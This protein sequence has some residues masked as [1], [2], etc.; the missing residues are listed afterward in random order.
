ME[1]LGYQVFLT[2][3]NDK[4]VAYLDTKVAESG[5]EASCFI[6]SCEDG[7]VKIEKYN[8]SLGAKLLLD[9]FY[10]TLIADRSMTVHAQQLLILKKSEHLEKDLGIERLIKLHTAYRTAG[11]LRFLN[12]IC[13]NEE[14]WKENDVEVYVKDVKNLYYEENE[15]SYLK[16][17]LMKNEDSKVIVVWPT[18]P[19]N[20]SFDCLFL[21]SVK[22]I[23][24]AFFCQITVRDNIDAKITECI[25]TE[26]FKKY[27]NV[28][29]EMK[30][31]DIDVR[32]NFIHGKK[33]SDNVEMITKTREN[34]YNENMEIDCY[35]LCLLGQKEWFD[36]E[37]MRKIDGIR[38]KVKLLINVQN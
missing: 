20:S 13:P 2:T 22:K 26:K 3:H 11:C 25:A 18:D 9:N 31:S 17:L 24:T 15:K 19:N 12:K 36:D 5:I 6:M 32:F 7:P 33:E 37:A 21:F 23:K 35:P 4:T 14:P 38:G 30:E 29:K 10:I 28:I 1:G 8:E 27:K 34:V 16:D